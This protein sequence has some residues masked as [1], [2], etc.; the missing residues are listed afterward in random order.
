MNLL[1]LNGWKV[2]RVIEVTEVSKDL[3]GGENLEVRGKVEFM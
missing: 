1:N 2:F 3:E